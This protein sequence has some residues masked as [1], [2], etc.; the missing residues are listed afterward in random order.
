MR[1]TY[2]DIP[3]KMGYK[4]DKYGNMMTQNEPEH[5]G[6]ET[7]STKLR[8]AQAL[9]DK[10][11]EPSFKKAWHEFSPEEQ[12]SLYKK[13]AE[14]YKKA[15]GESWRPDFFRGRARKWTFYG[16]KHGYVAVR[17]QHSGMMKIVGSA[18]HPIGIHVGMKKLLSEGTPIWAAATPELADGMMKHYGMTAVSPM[19]VRHMAPV[20]ERKGTLGDGKIHHI[21][22]DGTINIS[23][24]NL[25]GVHRK[26]IV[27]NALYHAA[28]MS[29]VA[30]HAAVQAYDTV[31]DKASSLVDKAK[32][33]LDHKKQ[34]G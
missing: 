32:S 3:R 7:W 13:F 29:F 34:N 11:K 18:G 15:T 30:A 22:E 12:D 20:L 25:D 21:D 10:A 27:G 6:K 16:N 33:L 31:K 9:S 24:P 2:G 1:E 8:K 26:K 14:S 5:V 23:Y 17:R 28:S 19:V 4:K